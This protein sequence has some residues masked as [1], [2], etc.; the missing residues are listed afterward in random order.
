MRRKAQKPKMTKEFV[1]SST[2]AQDINQWLHQKWTDVFDYVMF[3]DRVHDIISVVR[4]SIKKANKLIEK[5]KDELA[6]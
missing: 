5:H 3:I 1:L 2:I 4:K 6:D